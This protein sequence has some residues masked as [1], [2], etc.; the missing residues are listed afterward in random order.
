L[1][2]RDILYT[3]WAAFIDHLVDEYGRDKLYELIQ[4]GAPLSDPTSGTPDFVSIYGRTLPQLE[5]AWLRTLATP[6]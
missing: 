2:R 1:K 3:E 4:T 5:A 6:K